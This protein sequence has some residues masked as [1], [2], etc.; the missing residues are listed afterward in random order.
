[1]GFR[2]FYLNRKCC[3]CSGGEDMEQNF[4]KKDHLELG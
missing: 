3:L 1:M 2:L 4:K